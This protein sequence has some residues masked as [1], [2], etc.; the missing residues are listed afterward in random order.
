MKQI[1]EYEDN[2][3]LICPYCGFEFQDWWEEWPPANESGDET[4]IKC[5]ICEND[6]VATYNY[7]PVF[8][9]REKD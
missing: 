3:E 7:I 9:A 6:F 4:E 2:D 8:S 5:E 1:Q